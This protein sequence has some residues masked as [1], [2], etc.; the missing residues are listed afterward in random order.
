M[1]KHSRGKTFTVFCPTTNVLRQI[2]KQIIKRSCY[3][4]CFPMNSN[5]LFHESFPPQMFCCIQYFGNET[6]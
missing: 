5:F 1:A 3:H 4:E 6:F 2:V